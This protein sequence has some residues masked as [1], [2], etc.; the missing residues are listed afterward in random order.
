MAIY[1]FSTKDKLRPK[2]TELV[3]AVKQYCEENDLN[4]SAEMVKL[5]KE[6][7]KGLG[8]DVN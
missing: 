8:I 5:I 7:A 2:D 4:F 1:T 3:D 6:W